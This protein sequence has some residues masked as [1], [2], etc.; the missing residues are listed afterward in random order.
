MYTNDY[1]YAI[2]RNDEYLA[3]FG[4]KGMRWGVR[5]ARE[6]GNSRRLGRM[7][8]KAS[9][10]LAKLE[11]RAAS[12]K[13]YA[14][15]AAALGAVSWYRPY[16]FQGSLRGALHVG[17]AGCELLHAYDG[18]S[19]HGKR[20]CKCERREA[21]IREFATALHE[22][23]ADGVTNCRHRRNCYGSTY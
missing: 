22:I 5:K 23:L 6:T 1:M 4:I 18:P 20:R 11:K 13:K 15:R 10:K 9:K 16:A 2:E 21:V 7:Y 19:I 14:R 3:H 17:S 12:G 8:R